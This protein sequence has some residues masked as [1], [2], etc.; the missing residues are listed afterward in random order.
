M[1]WI[2]VKD[3]L[4]ESAG[5]YL[6]VANWMGVIEKSEFDGKENWAITYFSPTHWMPLP[7]LPGEN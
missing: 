4:P 3:R 7:K 6:V 5:L 2:K 1:E